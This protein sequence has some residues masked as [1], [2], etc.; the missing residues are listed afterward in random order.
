MIFLLFRRLLVSILSL[1]LIISSIYLTKTASHKTVI[2]SVNPKSLPILIIDAG[3]GGIDSGTS[4]VDG[5]EEKDINLSISIKLNEIA[6][7][8][9][10]KTMMTRTKDQLIG[11]GEFSTIRSEKQAD[12][13]KRLDI[14]EQQENCILIS[15]HQNHYE[16]SQYSGFQ[17]FFTN[18]HSQNKTLAQRLQTLVSTELQ[19]NNHRKI[20]T[21]GSEIYLLYH[22][23]KPAIMIEC[24]F[25][26]NIK[27]LSLL[28]NEQYQHQLAFTIA[29][30]IDMYLQENP[31][32][33]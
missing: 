20:K 3:H 16:Q 18:N 1:G 26:S 30:G 9:G 17:V 4:G 10:Y 12:I 19:P 8:M 2:T 22:C 27:E 21:I 11:E 6:N 33:V 28:K 24:G 25:L 29:K 14:V 5:T 31:P 13:Y 23:T 15:I 32:F 7:L